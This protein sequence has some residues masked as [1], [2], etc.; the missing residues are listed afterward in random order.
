MLDYELDTRFLENG[1]QDCTHGALPAVKDVWALDVLPVVKVILFLENKSR[2]VDVGESPNN[3]GDAVII[4]VEGYV[5]PVMFGR[6][7]NGEIL[8]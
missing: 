4:R 2:A 1:I 3:G 5:V 8:N 6:E 7:C